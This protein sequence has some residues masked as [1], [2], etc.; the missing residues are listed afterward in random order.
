VF[1]RCQGYHQIDVGLD[2]KKKKKKEKMEFIF[3]C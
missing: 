3:C 2:C 1:V